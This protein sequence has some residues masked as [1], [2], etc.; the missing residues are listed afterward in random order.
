[1]SFVCTQFKCQTVVFDPR[2]RTLSGATTSGQSRTGSD[3]SEGVIRIPENS[4]IAR[5]S[6]SVCLVS[7]PGHSI[8]RGLTLLQRCS[9]CIL[10]PKSTGLHT[11]LSILV[12]INNAVV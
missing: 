10:K 6:P 3:G 1:M 4:S 9:R 7:Y 5:A 2:D 12:N 11:L 8:E